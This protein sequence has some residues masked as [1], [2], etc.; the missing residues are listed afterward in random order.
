MKP[1]EAQKELAK[2]LFQKPIDL[3]KRDGKLTVR[4]GAHCFYPAMVW[5]PCQ[6][7]RSPYYPF[8]MVTVGNRQI[9]IGYDGKIYTELHDILPGG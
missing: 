1:A 5:K 3:G 4:D 9:Y 7:S 8:Y 2:K 6:E